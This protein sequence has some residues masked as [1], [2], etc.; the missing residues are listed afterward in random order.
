MS[1]ARAAAR[2]AVGA[3]VGALTV[4]SLAA[5]SGADRPMSMFSP[6]GADA[7][8]VDSHWQMLLLLGSVVWLVVMGFTL[9]AVLRRRRAHRE[10]EP[11]GRGHVVV[12]VGGA[13][14]P[15]LIITWVMADSVL[16]M[17]DTGGQGEDAGTVVEVAGHQFWWEVRYPEDGVVTANEIHVPVGEV[18]RLEMTA[19]DVIH[20]LWV[21]QLSGKVDLNPGRT[22]V[23]TINAQEP[24]TY[25]GQCAEYCGLQHAWMRFV[26]VAHEPEEFDGWLE[27]QSLPAEDPGAGGEPGDP[28]DPDAGD[29]DPQVVRGREVFM[30]SSC[31]YCHAVAGTEATGTMGPDLTHFASRQTIGAGVLPNDRE[32]LARWIVDPQAVKPGNAMPGTDVA[33]E[34]LEAMLDYLE[35]L[36]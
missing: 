20:S 16:V 6:S 12:A 26:V 25:W 28:A 35:S 17:R 30:S 27:A 33:G 22:T 10:D 18:V 32:S 5:C 8:R 2:T 31:V 14:V 15:A 29:Q 36:E 23:M 4:T 19:S 11:R 24:G 7:S 34:E 9:G 13:L 1:G 21:P 3:A